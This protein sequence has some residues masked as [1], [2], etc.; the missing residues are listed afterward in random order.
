MD[1]EE[2][3]LDEKDKE[4]NIKDIKKPLIKKYT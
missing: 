2:K 1:L 3:K 4:S